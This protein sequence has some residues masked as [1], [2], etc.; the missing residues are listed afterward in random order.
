MAVDPRISLGIRPAD[1]G[2]VFSSAL[3]NVSDLNQL[4][5]S[6][7]QAPL[8]QQLLQTNV[9]SQQLGLQA[10][11]GRQNL[12]ASIDNSQELVDFIDSGDF[13]GAQENLNELRTQLQASGQPVDRADEAMRLLQSN[14]G[15]LKQRATDA[16]ERGRQQLSG[17]RGQTGLTAGQ[18]ER[19]DLQ[20]DLEGAINQETGKLIPVKDMTATQRAAAIKLRLIAPPVGAAAKTV[21]VGGVPHVFDPVKQTLVPATV[22]GEQV[23]AETVGASKAT[24]RQREKFGELTGSSRAKAIDKGFERVAGITKNINTIDRALAALD[25]GAGTGAAEQFFPSIKAATRELNQIQGELALDVIGSVTFGALSQGELDLAQ[26]IALDTGLDGP[27]LRDVLQRKKVAQGKLRDYFNEQIQFLDQG[28]TIAGFLRSKQGQQGGFQQTTQQSPQ[29]QVQQP[30]QQ[31]GQPA[32]QAGQFNSSVL[33]RVVSEQDIQDTLN[34]NPG[35]TR[36]QLFQ[37]L[38]I[39]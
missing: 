10:E 26:R 15:L 37:Q 23:T 39:Q 3:R 7:A 29:Q 1:I 2:S 9:E 8:R 22:E 6:Q 16:I 21:D 13:Q 38:G 18:R 5:E 11:Q 14:P 30:A 35:L 25:R 17:L 31:V 36:D 12:I 32:Q 24:I 20:K 33:G 27:A 34:A 19:G 28:G 4:R